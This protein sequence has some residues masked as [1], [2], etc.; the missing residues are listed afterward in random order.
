[1]QGLAIEAQMAQMINLKWN[2][3]LVKNMGALKKDLAV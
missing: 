2:P 1:L 3:R